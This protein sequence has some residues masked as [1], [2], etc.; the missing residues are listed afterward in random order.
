MRIKRLEAQNIRTMIDARPWLTKKQRAHAKRQTPEGCEEF[1]ATLEPPPATDLRAARAHQRIGG[2]DR[3][4]VRP[5]GR[6]AGAETREVRPSGNPKM[7]RAVG[8]LGFKANGSDNVV[9]APGLTVC[10]PS[11]DGKL[12]E[13]DNSQVFLAARESADRRYS[14]YYRN[15]RKNNG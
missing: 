12:F 1:L 8:V 3:P 9:S 7:M 2:D 4:D 15:E 10:D 14:R 11:V 13:I 6:S 5:R